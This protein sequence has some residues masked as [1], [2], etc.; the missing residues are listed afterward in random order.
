MVRASASQSVDQGFTLFCS[1]NG[2]IIKSIHLHLKMSNKITIIRE[3]ANYFK[4]VK[5]AGWQLSHYQLSDT[6]ELQIGIALYNILIEHRAYL[7]LNL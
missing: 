1:L 4:S 5:I 2:S 7:I 6:G 3:R